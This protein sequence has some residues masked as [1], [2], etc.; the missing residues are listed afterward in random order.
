MLCLMLCLLITPGQVLVVLSPIGLGHFATKEELLASGTIHI[1][2]A[3][4]K[5]DRQETIGAEEVF[6]VVPVTAIRSI[7]SLTTTMHALW[8][9]KV[10]EKA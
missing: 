2:R 6:G 3:S 5:K 10:T 4:L 1:A 7:L 9:L 8:N